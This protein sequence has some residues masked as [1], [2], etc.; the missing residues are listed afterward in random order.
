M[1]RSTTCVAN[2][3][4]A[5]RERA[6]P[7]TGTDLFANGARTEGCAGPCSRE[8]CLRTARERVRASARRTESANG[9]GH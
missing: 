6:F 5:E 7:P 4:R 3:A 8:Q 2:G 9:L 1:R